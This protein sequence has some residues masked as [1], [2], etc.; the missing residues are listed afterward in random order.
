MIVGSALAEPLRSEG[1]AFAGRIVVCK[2]DAVY[3]DGDRYQVV[4]WKTG[5]APKDEA[6]LERKQLQLALYRLA[7]ARWANISRM[8]GRG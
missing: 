8:T 6:D 3:F 1:A 7:Y 5:K 4:D 2:I